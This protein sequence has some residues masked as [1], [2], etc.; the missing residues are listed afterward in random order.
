MHEYLIDKAR[1]QIWCNPTQ[2]NQHIIKPEKVTYGAGAIVQVFAL[3][4]H[5]DLPSKDSYAQ[6][7]QVGQWPPVLLGLFSQNPSWLKEK[8]FSFEEAMNSS[9]FYA[10]IYTQR[11]VN[12]PRS[13]VYFMYTREKCLLFAVKCDKTINVKYNTDDFYFR[14]YSNSYL[15]Q[16][17]QATPSTP[18]IEVKTFR[19][20]TVQE[21]VNIQVIWDNWRLRIGH[22][23]V[24]VNGYTVDNFDL[25]NVKPGDIVELIYDASVKRLVTWETSDLVPFTSIMDQK[26][27]YLL[28]YPKEIQVNQI[29]FQD[30]ID[31]FIKYKKTPAVTIGYFYPKNQL[32]AMRMI[33]HRDYSLTSE[34]V[35]YIARCITEDLGIDGS[36]FSEYQITLKIRQGGYNRPLI[37]DA[38]RIQELY[39]LSDTQITMSMSGVNSLVP[40][41]NAAHLEAAAYP[42]VMREGFGDITIEQVEQAY[43][44]NSMSV[45][46]A[47]T[48]TATDRT[49]DTPFAKLPYELAA[50]P[51]TVY[52]YDYQGKLLGVHLHD[53]GD[54]DYNATNTGCFMIEAI[55]GVGQHRTSDIVARDNI[56]LRPNCSYRVYRARLDFNQDPPAIFGDWTDITGDDTKYEVVD[57]VVKW[58]GGDSDQILRVRFDDTFLSYSFQA[59]EFD[60]TFIFPITEMERTEPGVDIETMQIPRGDLQIWIN[61]HN[62]V[63]DIDYV[64]KYPYICVNNYRYFKQPT[65]NV[66]QDVHV[67]FTGFCSDQMA[68]LPIKS[69]GFVINGALS[70]D[71]KYAVLDN[72]VLH[73]SVCGGVYSKEEVVF[74]EDHPTWQST[75]PLN[76]TPYQI[77]EMIAPLKNFTK[78]DT[79]PLY[80]QAKYVDRLVESYM[81]TYYPIPMDQPISVAVERWRLV[82]PFMS[83]L[84]ALC[85][86]ESLVFDDAVLLADMEVLEICKPYEVLLEYDPINTYN[87]L[88]EQYVNLTPTRSS[89]PLNVS[90]AQYR[91]LEAANRLYCDSKIGLNNFITFTIPT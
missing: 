74:F 41:W 13:N 84:V 60:G 77:D 34:Y 86:N 59:M 51:C 64:V 76:G 21:V 49:Y 45:I 2:D 26:L 73:I 39:K 85:E 43:G 40:V 81:D 88:P 66:L 42:L 56:T 90:R 63:R 33:T 19:P 37:H 71:R 69:K 62:L 16:L 87:E 89:T 55:V 30:D 52:E 38:N 11:G 12:I 31:V 44:Y 9:P 22:T 50:G 68:L 32:D 78:T 91:F 29:D 25:L 5:I 53:S 61:G 1:D 17:N 24:W 28:H 80:D 58:I 79:Y 75:S 67:R 46:L 6:V 7:F 3:S 72:K 70:N 4:R 65:T 15:R 8:W 83:K 27:K 14:F 47:N 10:N 82:S 48:P 57:G 36:D 20:Q 23:E 35:N 18:F 54:D